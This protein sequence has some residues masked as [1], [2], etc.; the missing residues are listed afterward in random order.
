[1]VSSE[2]KSYCKVLEGNKTLAITS[3]VCEFIEPHWPI[4]LKKIILS[5]TGPSFVSLRCLIWLLLPYYRLIPLKLFLYTFVYI[6]SE[7]LTVVPCYLKCLMHYLPIPISL[8]S[9]F[10][11][12]PTLILPISLFHFITPYTTVCYLPSI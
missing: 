9:I 7:H 3:N 2:I 10:I 11:P 8:L 12:K 5:V 4:T 6:F 1:M